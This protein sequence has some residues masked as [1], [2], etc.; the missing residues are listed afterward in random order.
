MGDH[1]R[2]RRQ[3]TALVALVGGAGILPGGAVAALLAS[4]DAGRIRRGHATLGEDGDGQPGGS[5]GAARLG[6]R[7]GQPSSGTRQLPPVNR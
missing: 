6:S 3:S 7:L 2:H 1:D 5:P 4:C